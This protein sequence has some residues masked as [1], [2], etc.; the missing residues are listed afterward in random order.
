MKSLFSA[1]FFLLSRPV[2]M[3]SLPEG[4]IYTFE[5]VLSFGTRLLNKAVVVND[6]NF[7]QDY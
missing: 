6:G 2:S 3:H 4:F 5:C 1:F 7:V